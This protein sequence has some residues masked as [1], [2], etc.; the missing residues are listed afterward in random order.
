MT[1]LWPKMPRSG[2]SLAQLPLRG[3]LLAGGAVPRR[4][5]RRTGGSVSMR[6]AQFAFSVGDEEQL[7]A[8]LR[9]LE[10]LVGRTP[11]ADCAQYALRWLGDAAGVSQAI[12]LVKPVGG[13]TLPT[14]AAHGVAGSAVTSFALP[15]DEWGNPLIAALNTRK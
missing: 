8:R 12:C 4:A 3:V 9:L 14:V 1:K 7:A 15:I 5:P 13:Q 10:G 6:A 2:L 11:V